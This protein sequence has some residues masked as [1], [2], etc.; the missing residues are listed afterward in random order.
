[1]DRGRLRLAASARLDLARGMESA[2]S[3]ESSSSYC[4]K[5]GCGELR[6]A[7]VDAVGVDLC[8][9]WYDEVACLPGE[10]GADMR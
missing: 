2:M 1:M 10:A 4:S 9:D 3:P 8:G 7:E 6:D 5:V